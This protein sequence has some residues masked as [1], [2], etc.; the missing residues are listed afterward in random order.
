MPQDPK[1]QASVLFSYVHSDDFCE[2][3]ELLKTVTTSAYEQEAHLYV[4][5]MGSAKGRQEVGG[6]AW[7][8]SWT[9]C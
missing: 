8:G 6:A 5:L 2:R 7:V 3:E 9:E 4:K 1:A